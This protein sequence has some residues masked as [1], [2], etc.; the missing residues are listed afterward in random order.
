[1]KTLAAA[2]LVL[3]LLAATP[4]MPSTVAVAGKTLKLNGM[5]VRRKIVFKVYVAGLYLENPSKDASAILAA[6]EV[7]SIRLHL[8]R[9]LR[10]KQISEAIQEGF[11]RSS[12]ADLPK[13]EERLRRL[14]SLLPDLSE[15]DEIAL[16][17]A[18]GK[19]TV[20]EMKGAERGV[21][22]GKDFADA[23]FSVWLGPNPVQEDL[24]KALLGS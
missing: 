2:T 1:M 14:A 16:S 3:E 12:K 17:Y 10:G 8:L 11:E 6:D 9:N 21:I 4:Q 20:V 19:G 7:K 22:E 5:G 15:G 24:K 13:L 23:L 18:P